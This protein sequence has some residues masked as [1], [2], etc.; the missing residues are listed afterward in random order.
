MDNTVGGEKPLAPSRLSSPLLRKHGN[1]AAAH[2]LRRCYATWPELAER[3]GARGRE[4]AARDAFWH[5]EHL[6]A[7][8]QVQ[9]P[10]VFADYTDWLAGLLEARGVGREQLAGAFGFLA[11]AIEAAQCPPRQEPHRRELL[12]LLRD[13]RDRLLGDGPPPAGPDGRTAPSTAAV[14]L[15]YY[16]RLMSLDRHGAT[17][18][19][20][21][22]LDGGGTVLSLYADVFDPCL[23]NTGRE[24]QAGRITVAHE[25][26]ISEVTRDLIHRYGPSVWA[27]P[28]PGAPVALVCCVPGEKHSIGLAMICDALHAAG[29][30]T[31]TVGA[32]LPA[33]SVV[34]ISRQAGADLVCLS[35]ALDVHL[36]AAEALAADLKRELPGVAVALGGAALRDQDE[37]FARK[38]GA[39]LTAPDLGAFRRVL[40]GWLAARNVSG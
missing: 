27:E 10:R 9:E 24:W 2:C 20:A 30:I 6:D 11:E 3:Y 26:Y 8:V 23:V 37:A 1:A 18:A 32:D 38:R 28:G 4:H 13:N 14:Y 39:D 17:Q 36:E 12:S 40:A 7:A 15:R 29:V 33:E 16:E 31:H 5:L 35:C 19:V 25:H 22:Y 34:A 21:D